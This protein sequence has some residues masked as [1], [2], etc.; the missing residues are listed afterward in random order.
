MMVAENRFCVSAEK[1]MLNK[2]MSMKHRKTNKEIS[3]KATNKLHEALPKKQKLKKFSKEELDIIRPKFKKMMDEH[4]FKKAQ[5]EGRYGLVN[6]QVTTE[7]Q[8][9][10]IVAVG[11]MIHFGKTWKTFPDFL[12]YYL[13]T[14][15]TPEWGKD[16]INKPED[17]RHQIIKLHQQLCLLQARQKREMTEYI[18]HFILE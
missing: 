17:K 10:R 12:L 4:Y 5:Y 16:E 2:V 13:I 11:N 14:K 3:L 7:F 9:G 18:K 6:Q 8:N 15:M 1:L